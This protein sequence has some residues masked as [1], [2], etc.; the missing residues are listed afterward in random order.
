MAGDEVQDALQ[1][2]LLPLFAGG[3]GQQ[4]PAG[5]A[6]YCCGEPAADAAVLA[7]AGRALSARWAVA[8]QA[9]LQH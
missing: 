9:L 7:A 6:R 2:L 5:L 1:A 3:E 4:A 8:R